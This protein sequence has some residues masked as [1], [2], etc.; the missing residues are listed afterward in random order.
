MRNFL[1]KRGQV[2]LFVIIA[3][4]IAAGIVSYF[5]FRP[6]AEKTTITPNPAEN[7]FLSCAENVLS[8]GA[9][10][11]GEQGG[12]IELPKFEPGS[13]YM[14][15][16]SQLDFLGSPVQY[17]YYISG[18]NIQRQ[19]VPTLESMQK[20]L[21]D[22]ISSEI[23]YCDLSAYE[24][25]GYEFEKADSA[26]ASVQIFDNKIVA[27][28]SYPLTIKH[29]DVSTRF[30]KHEIEIQSQ[31]GKFYK[32]AKNIY[33]KE[34]KSFFLE[35]YT[36]DV[37]SLYAPMSDTE[38]SCSPKIW[39]KQDI[40]K[41][42]KDAL[43]ANVQAL[44]VE[45]NYY[46]IKDSENRY[47]IVKGVSSSDSVNFLY[48]QNWPTQLEIYPSD[49]VIVSKPVGMQP[50]LGALGFCFV[51]YHFVYDVAFP[52]LVQIY[53]GKELFQFPVLV[54]IKNNL[55]R[56]SSVSEP[57]GIEDTICERKNTEVSVSVRDTAGSPVNAQVSFK[58]FNQI[59]DIGE[60]KNGELFDLFPQCVNGFVFASKEGY[61][62]GKMQIDT[63]EPAFASVF[64]KKLYDLSFSLDLA[65]VPLSSQENAVVTFSSPDY[66]TTILYPSQ[67]KISL[68]EGVYNVSVYVYRDSRINLDAYTTRECVKVP[69]SGIL[70]VLGLQEE[71]C[72]DISMPAQTLNT[73][74]GGGG[75]NMVDI[76]LDKIKTASKVRVSASYF[77]IPV[78]LQ[79]L[80]DNYELV[81]SSSVDIFIS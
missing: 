35:N 4:I 65:G 55:A 17:W 58:C 29:G 80:Q 75:N 59:C 30:S 18:N 57:V 26:S 74:L 8:D 14:P 19:K 31:T 72:F 6:G 22:Y 51:Q 42:I 60:A 37:L 45:G 81:D 48:S 7:L 15:T 11:L 40:E 25:Q 73:S 5:Y 33:D 68:S 20:Q 70:G 2:T 38:I 21:S 47:F 67:K 16:S 76:S 36:L 53:S 23:K 54:V 77:T 69:K 52:V 34:Q 3:L 71:K 12:Y 50:G 13:S 41:D 43:E 24:L 64:M 49:E 46:K 62:D 27:S 1:L 10:I 9:R 78:T 39:L 56:N 28:I 61:A 79:Q 44:K 66:T 32:T 63:N